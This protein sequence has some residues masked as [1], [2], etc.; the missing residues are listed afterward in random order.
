MYGFSG[1]NTYTKERNLTEDEKAGI[2]KQISILEK[3]K[4]NISE[5]LKMQDEEVN[6]LQGATLS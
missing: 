3:Q 6:N 1:G 4:G 2:K 5:N